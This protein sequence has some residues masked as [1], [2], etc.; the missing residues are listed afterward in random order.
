MANGEAASM[1][2][3]RIEDAGFQELDLIHLGG[4][5]V[6]VRSQG[7]TD[8]L[9]VLESTKDFFHLCFSNWVRWERAVIP[10]QR[11][12]WVR[13]Y[14]IP[15]HAWNVN[16]FKLCVFDC[17]RL[18]RVDKH[19]ADQGRLDYARVLI[20]TPDLEVVKRLEKL[21]VDGNLVEVQII[22][23]WGFELGDDACVPD[24]DSVSR[25]SLCANEELHCDPEASNQVDMLVDHITKRMEE[26]ITVQGQ[27]DDASASQLHRS[28][29]S[30]EAKGQLGM[31]VLE[32]VSTVLV[33]VVATSAVSSD[34]SGFKGDRVAE[35]Q[36]CFQGRR[37]SNL[38]ALG[39]P[40]AARS[41]TTSSL[42]VGR[43]RNECQNQRKRTLSCPPRAR[44]P[45]VPGPWSLD[46]LQEQNLG[47]AGVIFSAK[48]RPLNG[49]SAGG[50]QHKVEQPGPSKTIV[51]GALRHL[52]FSLKRVA[53]LPSEDRKEVMRIL[54]K[55]AR[56]RRNRGKDNQSCGVV[57]Q[58][59]SEG[60]TTSSSVNNDWKNWVALQ[61]NY[62]V[63]ED[64]V[65]NIGNIIGV[66]FAGDMT[67]IFSVLSKSGNGKHT[68]QGER[69]SSRPGC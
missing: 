14:G 56:R 32:P 40:A 41:K 50:V 10:F 1:V 20:A 12:A 16:F 66:S 59:S 49:I 34:P 47:E 19:T 3:Q 48:E 13:I 17:G 28:S 36:A 25:A 46:W 30:A 18:L 45:V 22:E 11:G 9:P 33:P 23:E 5:R 55:N 8:V 7:G 44:K 37:G 27:H 31:S 43:G 21:L 6:L 54:K 67:N 65:M 53:R 64:D 57:L 42:E 24:D 2:W 52:L 51:G 68:Q 35:T 61:G 69:H 58:T 15:L 29:P 38:E 60:V 62:R 26:G 39:M 4:D 63:V